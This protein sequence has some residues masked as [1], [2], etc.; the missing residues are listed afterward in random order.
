[1]G[2]AALAAPDPPI[3]VL[4]AGE[5]GGLPPVHPAYGKA[6]SATPAAFVCRAGVRGLPL[7]EAAGL[8]AA[9]RRG[10]KAA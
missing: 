5:A 9:L 10:D 7:R 3:C 4:R 6:A 1:L 2:R 8:A